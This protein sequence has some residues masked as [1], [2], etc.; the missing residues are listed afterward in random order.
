ML[1]DTV[2]DTFAIAIISEM[3]N[4]NQLFINSDIILK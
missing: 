1:T 3:Q 4:C 2:R